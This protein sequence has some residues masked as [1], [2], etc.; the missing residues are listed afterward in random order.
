VLARCPKRIAPSPIST[1]PV[2][3]LRELL[4]TTQLRQG[5]GDLNALE[6]SCPSK[7]PEDPFRAE[8]AVGHRNRYRFS[9]FPCR[10]SPP[11]RTGDQ[12]RDEKK[13]LELSHGLPPLII[14]RA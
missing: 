13:G 1:D 5:E 10:L 12:R 9:F 2:K 14:Y 6:H 11:G 4:P 3:R 7:I 8:K